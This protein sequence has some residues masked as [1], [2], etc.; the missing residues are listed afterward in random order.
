MESDTHKALVADLF[1]REM[2][3]VFN[4]TPPLGLFATETVVALAKP[5]ESAVEKFREGDFR[6]VDGFV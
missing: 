6:L 2:A 3:V 5:F 1:K 4:A